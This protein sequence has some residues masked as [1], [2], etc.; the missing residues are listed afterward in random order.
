MLTRP[1]L[2]F[3]TLSWELIAFTRYGQRWQLSRWN[4]SLVPFRPSSLYR[5]RTHTLSRKNRTSFIE[6]SQKWGCKS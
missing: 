6:L 1:K 3:L 5:Q 2:I 4:E